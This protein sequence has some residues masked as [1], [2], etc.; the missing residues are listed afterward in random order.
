MD[1]MYSAQLR[2][3]RL[4]L[5]PRQHHGQRLFFLTD[6]PSGFPIPEKQ[7]PPRYLAAVRKAEFE[8]GGINHI[9]TS[10][11]LGALEILSGFSSGNI[12]GKAIK[13]LDSHKNFHRRFGNYFLKYRCDVTYR[14]NCYT[15]PVTIRPVCYHFRINSCTRSSRANLT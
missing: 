9:R 2:C 10:P 13:A 8:L 12:G 6:S 7:F 4:F 11:E 5:L 14:L 15:P 1:E 3:L